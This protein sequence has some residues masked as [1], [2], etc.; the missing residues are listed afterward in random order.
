M[1]ELMFWDTRSESVSQFCKL[2]FMETS[3]IT[4]LNDYSVVF[5]DQK[6]LCYCDLRMF[7]K[8]ILCNK[9]MKTSL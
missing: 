7:R 8:E 9:P 3:F 2:D 4:R 1:G 6:E 5:G